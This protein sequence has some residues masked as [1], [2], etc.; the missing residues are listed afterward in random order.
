M[1]GFFSFFFFFCNSLGEAVVWGGKQQKKKKG[2]AVGRNRK[3]LGDIGNLVNRPITRFFFFLFSLS[4]S[5]TLTHSLNVK[6]NILMILLGVFLLKF[7][8]K[9]K[10]QPRITR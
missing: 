8:P 4:H 5:Q 10:Q 2:I 7:L 9:Y 1:S 3:I 6:S